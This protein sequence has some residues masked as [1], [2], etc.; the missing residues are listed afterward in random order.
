MKLKQLKTSMI[1]KWFLKNQIIIIICLLLIINFSGCIFGGGDDL[2]SKSS[3]DLI[4]RGWRAFQN[5]NY[6]DSEKYFNELTKR[7]DA[8]LVG[9]SGLGWTFLKT[10]KYQNA[11]NEFNRFF[12][13]DSLGVY[14]PADSL[15]RDVRAGQVLV[16]SAL[17]EHGSVITTSSGF[18]AN[19]A[20]NNNWRFRF[21]RS[22]TV[23]DVRLLRAVSLIALSNFTDAY[24]MVRLVDSSFETN[25]NTIEGRLLLVK[26]IEE[27]LFLR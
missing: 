21:D 13:L 11:K 26:K 27:L 22:I 18:T 16:H 19:N 23:V 9:H 10:F 2:S 8:Y 14:A 20:T 24:I 6:K 15:T 12:S 1:L 4:E 3:E 5:G 25:I 17:S 7:E